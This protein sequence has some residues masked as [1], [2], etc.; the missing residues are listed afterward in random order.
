ME[1]REFDASDRHHDPL[2][3]DRLHSAADPITP[4][5]S[6]AW[7]YRLSQLNL[8]GAI[9]GRDAVSLYGSLGYW[10]RGAIVGDNFDT[11]FVVR[12]SLHL[13]LIV[14]AL[15]KLSRLNDHFTRLALA[16]S[17]L[18][19]YTIAEIDPALQTESQIVFI[20]LLLL[21]LPEIWADDTH[22]WPLGLGAAA[23]ILVNANASI[24]IARSRA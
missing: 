8:N 19:P 3:D 20:G 21:S 2:P 16:I 10:L 11:V 9:F 22:Y 17:L 12:L 1:N 5:A 18:F 7:E 4:G 24:G 23:G 15:L 13:L 14:V 6:T